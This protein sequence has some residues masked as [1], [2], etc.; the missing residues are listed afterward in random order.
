M[1]EAA[2][3]LIT[4]WM[5]RQQS[6]GFQ[7]VRQAPPPPHRQLF[8]GTSSSPR[9]NYFSKSSQKGASLQIERPSDMLHQ[10]FTALTKEQRR[11]LPVFLKVMQKSKVLIFP[12]RKSFNNS[13]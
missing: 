3:L 11:N 7:P 10:D 2:W 4:I 1:R 13:K 9:N 12:F 6:V 8:G 5:L